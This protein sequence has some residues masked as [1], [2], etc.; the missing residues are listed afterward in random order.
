MNQEDVHVF[1]PSINQTS[2]LTPFNF[3]KYSIHLKKDIGARLQIPLKLAFALT[4]PKAQ[5]M[6]LARVIVDCKNMFQYGQLAV[7][8]SRATCKKGLQILNFTRKLVEKPPSYILE[9]FNKP[10]LQVIDDLSCCT[11]KK[12]DEVNR[13][14]QIEKIHIIREV[15]DNIEEEF[16][17]DDEIEF[18]EFI[19]QVTSA[20]EPKHP[21]PQELN[22]NVVLEGL[23]HK[24]CVTQQ[25]KEENQIVS[26]LFENLDDSKYFIQ[27]FLG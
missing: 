12:L 8:I 10:V 4:I 24:A 3:T 23:K 11:H 13:E 6:T 25:Q 14:V 22:L 17:S 2:I 19:E 27:F 9:F 16:D 18:I 1:F 21:L 7:A 5:G 26:Y 15:T 20:R